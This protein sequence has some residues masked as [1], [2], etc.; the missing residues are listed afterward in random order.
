MEYV[1]RTRQCVLCFQVLYFKM[2]FTRELTSIVLHVAA[3]QLKIR[4]YGNAVI[5]GVSYFHPENG[6]LLSI[7]SAANKLLIL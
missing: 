2:K 1:K 6:L 4:R 7:L 3:A 5:L